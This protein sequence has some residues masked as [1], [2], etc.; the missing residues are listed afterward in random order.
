M[1]FCTGRCLRNF[2]LLETAAI[3]NADRFS[4][5][6]VNSSDWPDEVMALVCALSVPKYE[7]V[8]LSPRS[9]LPSLGV[10]IPLSSV[11]SISE[12]R[13]LGDCDGCISCRRNSMASRSVRQLRNCHATYSQAYPR[14]SLTPGSSLVSS[15]AAK[16]AFS[17]S[18]AWTTALWWQP[19]VK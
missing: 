6:A 5:C 1:I 8:R 17:A 19:S 4:N 9:A 15:S 10:A 14:A 7:G 16:W 11:R 12:P 2:L 13:S 3:S 18:R